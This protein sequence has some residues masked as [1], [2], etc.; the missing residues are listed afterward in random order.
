MFQVLWSVPASGQLAD[1]WARSS[2]RN[3]ITTAAEAI[4]RALRSDPNDQG[5][6]RGANKRVFIVPPH[7]VDLRVIEEDRRVEIL[8]VREVRQRLRG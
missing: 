8:A 2:N 6:S 4:D 3:A 1:I 5:E 7:I